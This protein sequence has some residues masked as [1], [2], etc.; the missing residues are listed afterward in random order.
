VP[1]PRFDPRT[2]NSGQKQNPNSEIK[3]EK[4]ET[5]YKQV[6]GAANAKRPERNETPSSKCPELDII[7]EI[8]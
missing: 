8:N 1:L 6:V 2:F 7:L 5:S 4:T 3:F